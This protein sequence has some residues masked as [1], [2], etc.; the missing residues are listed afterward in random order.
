VRDL[1]QAFVVKLS[2]LIFACLFVGWL[3]CNSWNGIQ[4]H[5]S[6]RPPLCLSK[7]TAQLKALVITMQT[8]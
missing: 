8:F 3:V 4:D 2:C 6:A 7:N 1:Q 5:T